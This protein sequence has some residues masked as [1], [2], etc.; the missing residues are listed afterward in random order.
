[1]SGGWDVQVWEGH[2]FDQVWER[3]TSHAM[4]WYL[5]DIARRFA[6]ASQY[7]CPI[8]PPTVPNPGYL[9]LSSPSIQT[10]E[11]PPALHVV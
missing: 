6:L 11:A 3:C 4:V 7:R 8:S 2:Q 10:F 5:S 9:R 1:M